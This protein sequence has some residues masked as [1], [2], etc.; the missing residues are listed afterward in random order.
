MDSSPLLSGAKRLAFAFFQVALQ[1]TDLDDVFGL[2][3]FSYSAIPH[4]LTPGAHCIEPPC[5][6]LNGPLKSTHPSLPK[7]QLSQQ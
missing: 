6:A 2:W 3:Q 7:H 4:A 1:S 5:T